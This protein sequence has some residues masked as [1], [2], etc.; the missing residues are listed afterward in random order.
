[1][2]IFR[3]LIILPTPTYIKVPSGKK[4]HEIMNNHLGSPKAHAISNLSN[5]I[6]RL[7]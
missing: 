1:M 3:I 6:M 4:E 5:K 7:F 2:F